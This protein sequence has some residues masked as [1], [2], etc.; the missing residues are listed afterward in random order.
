MHTGLTVV[1]T[2]FRTT[3]ELRTV[4][5][6]VGSPVKDARTRRVVAN[7]GY[8]LRPSPHQPLVVDIY[9]YD[10]VGLGQCTE[11][12]TLGN[13]VVLT[14]R[15]RGGSA[16]L[17]TREV[18]RMRMYD[19]EEQ[20]LHLYPDVAASPARLDVDSV[21]FGIVSSGHIGSS[22][23]ARPGLPFSYV[24][25]GPMERGTRGVWSSTALRIGYDGFEITFCQT[26]AYWK[27]LVDRRSLRHQMVVGIRSTSGG[28][29]DWD[30]VN[31]VTCLLSDFVGWVNHCASPV[32]H[33]KAYRRGRLVY[34]GYDLH[35]HPTVQRDSVPWLPAGAGQGHRDV[36]E[37][38]FDAVCDTLNRNR[39]DRGVF[40][41]VLQLL[42]SQERGS[43]PRSGPSLLYLR[44][45]FG[46]VAILTSMLAGANSNRG[47]YDTMV[48]CV[49]QLGVPDE[50]PFENVRQELKE[51]HPDLWWAKAQCRVQQK[52]WANGSLCRPMANV[53]NWI[54]HVDDPTNAERLI[55]LA[56]YQGYFV[57]V[58][59]WLADLMLMKVVGHR[60]TYFNRLTG[61]EE[62]L[63]W[64]RQWG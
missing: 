43:S 3:G 30:R 21:V 26:S 39:R 9:G 56:H 32:F 13:G 40:H 51:R 4:R 22:G 50:L 55:S 25:G 57:E 8:E 52:E 12:L 2:I 16:E 37:R 14:G 11:E 64:E 35:P 31:E 23:W 6:A 61:Q 53:E 59:I 33:V 62:S 60:G 27:K 15:T 49:R 29:M 5:D 24:E 47:R 45:T 44:D 17:N 38:T 28:V 41:L 58:S 7:V 63:P 36:V 19:I 18:R 46:A 20:M 54:L 48:Q 1:R 34:C 42:R 10:L